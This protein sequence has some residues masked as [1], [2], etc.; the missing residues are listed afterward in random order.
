[1][2]GA[3][4]A[5][6]SSTTNTADG[7][8]TAS[9]TP[10][11]SAARTRTAEPGGMDRTENMDMETDTSLLQTPTSWTRISEPGEDLTHSSCP[12]ESVTARTSS[13]AP[14]VSS[15]LPSA[16]PSSHPSSTR[17]LSYAQITNRTTSPPSSSS[18]P[19]SPSPLKMTETRRQQRTQILRRTA[20]GTTTKDILQTVTAQMGVPEEQ[21]F[22]CVIRDPDDHRRFYVTYRTQQMK[23]RTTGKGYYIGDLHI[24]PTDDYLTGYIPHPPYYIDRQTLDDLLSSFGTVKETS[25]VTT[26][27]NTRIGGYKFKLKLKNDVGRPTSLLYNG[28]TMVIRYQDDVKQCAFCK[29]YG[30]IISAC[31]TKKAADADRQRARDLQLEEDRAAWTKEHHLLQTE[32]DDAVLLI[33]S[34]HAT[35]KRQLETVYHQVRRELCTSKSSDANM[36][37]WED[38]CARESDTI[39]DGFAME[40]AALYEHCVDQQTA[41]SQGY[42]KRGITLDIS[43]P[44]PTDIDAL[45]NMTPAPEPSSTDQSDIAALSSELWYLY[46]TKVPTPDAIEAPSQLP[47]SSSHHQQVASNPDAERIAAEQRERARLS[48]EKDRLAAKSRE[49][50]IFKE[51]QRIQA[52]QA[53]KEK[54]RQAAVLR[55]VQ[56]ELVLANQKEQADRERQEMEIAEESDAS[57]DDSKSSCSESEKELLTTMEPSSRVERLTFSRLPEADRVELRRKYTARLPSGYAQH[58]CPT[59]IRFRS[60]TPNLQQMIQNALFEAVLSTDIPTMNPMELLTEQKGDVYDITVMTTETLEA[61]LKLLKLPKC[62]SHLLDG[63]H[64]TKNKRYA[65]ATAEH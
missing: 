23:T 9:L 42:T 20:Y 60:R 25:F 10:L 3:V 27:R 30:H 6:T 1:M 28:F 34:N 37:V 47:S 49:E 65:P 11:I 35:A 41:L 55:R 2:K 5:P 14:L 61:L 50:H 48:A 46:S 8:T 52:K 16:N 22:E 63:P 45:L 15:L 7:S 18:A 43:P 40:V 32:T 36:A 58:F 31:R 17:P 21:L 51:Q 38:I 33:Q 12:Q 53:Q 19:L 13:S 56:A 26:E 44:A 62:S 59:S 54:A 64:V 4:R 29:R 39:H 24:R 57:F